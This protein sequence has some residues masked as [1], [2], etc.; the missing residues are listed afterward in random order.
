[1]VRS[2]VS[3]VGVLHS[4]RVAGLRVFVN[5]TT[6]Q[7]EVDM[8]EIDMQKTELMRE[9]QSGGELPLHSVFRELTGLWHK[10]NPE[11][12]SQDL[13]ALL[14]TRPQALSQWKTGSDKSKRP[15]WS[16]IVLLCEL[17]RRQIVIT[18]AG[19]RLVQLRSKKSSHKE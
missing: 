7:H 18:P 12:R 6:K 5:D 19:M 9:L 10:K 4:V 8:P 17:T 3:F 1:M 16:A 15:P 2:W 13:A 14:G 11:M